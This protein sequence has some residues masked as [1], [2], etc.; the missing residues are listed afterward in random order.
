MQRIVLRGQG[1]AGR[2]GGDNGDLIIEVRVREHN[3]FTRDGNN[4]YCDIPIT[5]AEAALGAEINVPLL[6]SETEKYTIPEG[7]QTGT[8]FTLRGKGITDINTKRR[9]DLI[10]TVV[11]DTPQGLN[12]KQ[13]ELL[14][15]F[16]ESLGESNNK[17]TSKFFKKIFK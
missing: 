11:V 6:G 3:L 16:S 10:F 7:T 1:S 9:G 13:K 15:A 17:K 12:G 14:R 5:F 8:R 4:V 2:N